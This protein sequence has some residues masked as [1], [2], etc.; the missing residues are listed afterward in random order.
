MPAGDLIR[1]RRLASGLSQA[2]LALRARTS[3]AAV[4]RIERGLVSPTVHTVEELLLALGEELRVGAEPLVSE[5]DR[6]HL[7][8]M[9]A[10]E[11]EAR[12]ELAWSWNRLAGEIAAAGERARRTG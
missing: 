4:S 3:Q 11:P 2:Q 7:A 5:A 10:R 8:D 9:K 1:A 12:V 6:H